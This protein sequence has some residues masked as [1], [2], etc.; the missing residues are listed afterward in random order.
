LDS[1][2]HAANAASAVPHA[3][4]PNPLGRDGPNILSQTEFDIC[5]VVET[6]LA[7]LA[8]LEKSIGVGASDGAHDKGEPHLLKSRGMW[9]TT[10][11]QLCSGCPR[12]TPIEEQFAAIESQLAPAQ[13]GAGTLP[14]GARV[15]FSVGVFS[16]AQVPTATL[17]PRISVIAAKYGADI[18]M[19]F[20]A[21]DMDT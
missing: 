19:K 4:N 1:S 10:V 7:T 21:P 3:T 8:D 2:V 15:Y 18:A 11:W 16:D 17:T 12:T 20:Y 9:Q 6:A 13:L 14:A 5:L